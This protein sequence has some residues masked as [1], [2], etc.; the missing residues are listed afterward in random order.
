M[1]IFSQS[2]EYDM[3]ESLNY[4]LDFCQRELICILMY[5]CGKEKV[6]NLLCNHLSDILRHVATCMKVETLLPASMELYITCY[7]TYMNC[8]L[9]FY[10]IMLF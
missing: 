2:P 3:Q 1:W 10:I 7:D 6:R 8:L 9:S 5:I 4:F